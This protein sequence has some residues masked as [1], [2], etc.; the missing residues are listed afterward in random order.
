M[1]YKELYDNALETFETRYEEIDSEWAELDKAMQEAINKHEGEYT[2]LKNLAVCYG[3]LKMLGDVIHFMKV[4]EL[5]MV[6]EYHDHKCRDC[7]WLSNEKSCIG[8]KCVNPDR[9]WKT[10]TAMW[11]QPSAKACKTF[12]EKGAKRDR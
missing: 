9:K 3:R 8:R 4:T 7:K 11:H 12:E 2:A 1:D 5:G 6:K 10:T